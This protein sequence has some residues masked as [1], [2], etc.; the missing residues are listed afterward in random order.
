M[1]ILTIGLTH[2]KLGTCAQHWRFGL[3][4]FRKVSVMRWLTSPRSAIDRLRPKVFSSLIAILVMACATGCGKRDSG[5]TLVHVEGVVTLDG[6]PVE[7]A[8]LFFAPAK[9]PSAK[10]DTDKNGKFRLMTNRPGDG[11]VAGEFQV[12][13]AKFVLDPATANDP[14]PAMKNELPDKYNSPATSGLTATINA[15]GNKPLVFELKND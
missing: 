14:V 4:V 1:G 3:C 15:S 8:T 5:L 13:I 2:V 9:G 11:A 12:S 7:G 10:A 6:K